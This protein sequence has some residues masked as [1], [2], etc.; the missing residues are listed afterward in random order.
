M[1]S[2]RRKLDRG[3]PAPAPVLDAPDRDVGG[4][5]GTLSRG[6][7]IIDRLLGASQPMTLAE[8]AESVR[9]DQSTTLR[10]L[11]SLEELQQVIR[12]G[13]GKKYAC[14][15]KA[16]RPLSL[17]HPLEQLRRETGPL[18]SALSS[19]IDKS[20]VLVLYLGVERLVVEL[21]L[22]AGTLNPYYDAWLKGPLHGS[23]PGKALLLTLTPDQRR[24][25]LG[26]EPY[27][28]C[29][30]ATLT[31]WA[32]LEVDLGKAAERGYVTVRDEYYDGLTAIACNF[33][34]WGGRP[35]GC[36]AVTGHTRDIPDAS[37]ASIGA[38]LVRLAALMPLQASSLASIDA[39]CG[40]A[41]SRKG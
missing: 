9:L 34:N 2:A 6:L 21:G 18:L 30:P 12:V 39:F 38:E 23:G 19:E 33:R 24:A 37:V 41:A 1:T 7:A 8:I 20:V 26:P 15:P 13:D 14:S 36:I 17:L 35:V 32:A 10:L 31:S 29:T 5:S 11:R 28:A 22:S 16:L 27:R 4:L 40:R 25:L 3:L